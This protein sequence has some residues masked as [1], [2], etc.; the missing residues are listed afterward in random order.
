MGAP[1]DGLRII[2]FSRIVAGPL[3]TQIFADYGAEVVKI[4]QPGHGDDSR[5]WVPPQAPNAR[6]PTSSR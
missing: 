6:R 1:L 4:E 5:H 2:D 3:A